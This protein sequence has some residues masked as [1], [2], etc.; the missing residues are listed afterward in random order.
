MSHSLGA[1][2]AHDVD[3]HLVGVAHAL[4]GVDQQRKHRADEHDHHLRPQAEAEPQH[5]QRQEHQPRRGVEGGDERIEHRVE[6]RRAAEQHA[7]RQA[8][9]D[10]QRRAR[11]R[12]PEALTP[13]GAQIVPVANMF[14]S[15]PATWLGVVKNSLVPSHIVTKCGNS[16][17]TSSSTAMLPTPSTVGSKRRHRLS[18]GA[19]NSSAGARR[20]DRL[21]GL[22]VSLMAYCPARHGNAVRSAQRMPSVNTT[23]ITMTMRMQANMRSSAKMSPNRAI[24]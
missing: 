14:H 17:Q 13:S 8:D 24:A 9:D 5:Q 23:A 2:R 4:V 21:D 10:R 6:G 3:Q 18:A 11:A 1:E 22:R 7:E 16:S 20:R 15:V 12:T 19:A